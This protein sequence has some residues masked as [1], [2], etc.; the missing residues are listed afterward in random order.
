MLLYT[1]LLILE[2]RAKHPITQ[3]DRLEH[4]RRDA[5]LGRLPPW[6]VFPLGASSYIHRQW[7]CCRDAPLGR[8]PPWGVFPVGASSPL[9]RLP[10]RGVFP[11]G[12]SSYT[13]WL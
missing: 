7:P 5:P 9:G 4:R 10:R 8:L 3:T 12:A 1:G 2:D 11:V 6:G 13:P